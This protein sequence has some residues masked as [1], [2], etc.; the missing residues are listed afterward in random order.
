ME[1]KGGGAVGL[2]CNCLIA[3]VKTW[4][5]CLPRKQDVE[6]GKERIGKLTKREFRVEEIDRRK[7]ERA[8]TRTCSRD[9]GARSQLSSANLR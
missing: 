1:L 4:S 3:V 8:L 6:K 7:L 9:H 2:G 5:D